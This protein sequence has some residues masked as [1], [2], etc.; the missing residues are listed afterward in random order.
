MLKD[1]VSAKKKLNHG[2][3][4]F[5]NFFD[6]E[7]RVYLC[8]P[9]WYFVFDLEAS[10]YRAPSQVSETLPTIQL[11][12]RALKLEFHAPKEISAFGLCLA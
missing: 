12:I 1:Q 3:T 8:H 11:N 2:G 4:D 10:K 7:L 6:K 5:P 9:W